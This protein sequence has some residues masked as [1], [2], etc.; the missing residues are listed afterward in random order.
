MKIKTSILS[1]ALLL[2]AI[3]ASNAAIVCVSNVGDLTTDVLYANPNG[4]LMS[5]GT[6]TMGYFSAGIT[7]SSINTNAK[8]F[9]SLGSFTVVS[10]FTP[11]GVMGNLGVGGSG[12]ADNSDVA[13]SMAGGQL[14]S[15]SA[16]YGRTI[17]SIVTNAASLAAAVSTSSFA[18][19]NIGT[20]GDDTTI[21]GE[22]VYSS[23]PVGLTP[24]LGTLGTYTGDPTGLL[25]SNSTF[26]T[27]QM[28]SAIPETS[29]ALLGGLGVLGLL[30]RRR[31]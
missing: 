23:S 28:V 19:V 2:G 26:T 22:L 31:I 12:Y 24:V 5:S 29:T 1:A 4:T 9:S 30:R 10:S 25:G 8:L 6:V 3:S 11:G 14:T 17:Y 27:L 15:A 20:F 13:T 21:Q 16:L 18:V 7:D